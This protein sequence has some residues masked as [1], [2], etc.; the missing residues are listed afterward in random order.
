MSIVTLTLNPALDKSAHIDQLMATDK[1]YCKN[2]LFAPGGG[3]INVSRVIHRLGGK[4]IAIGQASGYTGE[5]LKSM[6]AKEGVPYVAY[7]THEWTRENIVFL[8]ESSKKQY[9]FGFPGPHHEKEDF[10]NAFSLVKTQLK[11]NDLLVLSGSL[12]QGVPENAYAMLSEYAKEI[13]VRVV[14]DTHGEAYSRALDKGVYLIKPNLKELG[15]LYKESDISKERAI[16]LSQH[17]IEKEMTEIVVLSLGAKGAILL[18]ESELIEMEAPKVEAMSAVGAG[19]SMVAGICLA[20]QRKDSM[21]DLLRLA[22]ACGSATAK[23]DGTELCDRTSVE[24][25]FNLIQ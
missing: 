17:L 2:P 5:L 3:G 23:T 20:L 13:G 25:L 9:R 4:T 8:E 24:E 18:T 12:P 15:Q 21:K 16:E 19:D 7:T 10:E 6:L 1:M 14:L 22:I 11:K